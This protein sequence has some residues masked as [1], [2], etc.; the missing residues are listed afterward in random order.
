MQVYDMLSWKIY[1]DD[2]T[3]NFNGCWGF[4]QDKYT[5]INDSSASPSL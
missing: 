4:N 5:Y 1:M 2:K 3:Q